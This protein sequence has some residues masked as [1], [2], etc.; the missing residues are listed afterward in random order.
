MPHGITL[1]S[2]SPGAAG[3][4]LGFRIAALVNG[5]PMA[6]R[7]RE[8]SLLSEAIAANRFT[9][10]RNRTTQARITEKGTAIVE[11]HGILL[12]RSPYLGSFWGLSFYEGLGEQFRRLAT[13][14]EVK[15]VVL[16][17]DSPGGMVTGLKQCAAALEELA[18]KKPVFALAHDMAASA[19]YWLACVAQ[20]FSVTPDG[21]V[22]SIGV[23]ASHVSFAEALDREGVVFTTFTAGATKADL[24]PYALLDDGAAAEQQFGIERAYDRFVAHVARHRPL[25]DA[26]IRATDA[27]TFTGDKAVEARLAD[28]VETLEDMIE[29][30]EKDSPKVKRR[31][32]S[33][34]PGS[35]A[36]K[37]P[38]ERDPVR[39][40]DDVPAAGRPL[41]QRG[42]RLMSEHT[43]GA[44][45]RFSAADV[46]EAVM[47]VRG[48]MA[49][50]DGSR[51]A[52]R[53]AA[54]DD[55]AEQAAGPDKVA[56]AVEAE[57]ARIFG[58]L[59]SAEGK[60]RPK[61]AV[62]L[63]KSGLAVEAAVDVL[64]EAPTEAAEAGG[65]DAAKL[66]KAFAA[67]VAKPGNTAG[68]KPEADGAAKKQSFAD[69][70]GV[71]AKKS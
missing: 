20:E 51:E 53:Q 60:A 14:P 71:T 3:A 42:A 21:E 50:A 13:D 43:E 70:C 16:D 62:K 57:R 40:A 28:R 46:A 24:N 26:E 22:G 25:D 37:K 56:A 5:Q 19:G 52:P 44:G 15:R 54:S 39:P 17:V 8:L 61:M 59:E 34:E 9:L 4:D 48:S 63:A 67:E 12:N 7:D 66:A 36:G 38:P 32:K 64:A 65:G 55:K 18:D 45:G 2:Q 1:Q 68:V 41:N 27:R 6:M 35:R 47:A 31:P 49:R 69:F 30:V 23:R 33:T 10:P 11:V 58:I 29:R